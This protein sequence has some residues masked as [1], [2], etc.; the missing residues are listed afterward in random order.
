MVAKH[1]TV[2]LLAGM[3]GLDNDALQ[4]HNACWSNCYSM[5]GDREKFWRA[6]PAT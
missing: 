1:Q 3:T 2:A 4:A 6:S 5:D